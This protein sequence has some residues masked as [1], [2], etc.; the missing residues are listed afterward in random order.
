MIPGW[1]AGI[2]QF[3]KGSKGVLLVPSSLAYGQR[4]AGADIPADAILRFDVELVDIKNAPAQPAAGP[5]MDEAELR[6]QIEA[7][8]QQQGK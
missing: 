8:Q 7:M 3:P 6:R 5:Q 2:A 1:D 4:G